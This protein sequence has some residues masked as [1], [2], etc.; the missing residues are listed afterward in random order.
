MV[1]SGAEAVEHRAAG[2]PA[3]PQPGVDAAAEVVAQVRA[4]PTGGLVDGEVGGGGEGGRH[5]A[6]SETTRA[7]G[8]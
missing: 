6:Q 2:K 3:L 8:A 4:G 1:Q 7:V 5:A